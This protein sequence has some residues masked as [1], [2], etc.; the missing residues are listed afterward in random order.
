MGE[1]VMGNRLLAS[2]VAA[3]ALC[4][5]S[6]S[7]AHAAE[8][9]FYFGMSGGMASQDLSK[10]ALDV[11]GALIVADSLA[12]DDFSLLSYEPSDFDDNDAAWALQVGYQWG[13]YFAVELGYV[14][15]GDAM[16]A[17]DIL[18]SDDLV[19]LEDIDTTVSTRFRNS[20][21]TAAAVGIFPLGQ[22]F[23][24]HGRGGVLFARSR[25]RQKVDSEDSEALR[26][27]PFE[28]RG[29]STDLFAGLGAAWNINPSYSLRVEYTRYLNV[30]DEEKTLETDIDLI[31][32]T[33]L[34]R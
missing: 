32:L 27:V 28:L 19:I 7:G 13:S 9:G 25:I 21:I 10:K 23:E 18:V 14:N 30:G 16:H 3:G 11:N 17:A 26:V 20:G 24:V 15:L 31:S 6:V 4:V 33:L 8:G 1:Q 22:H 29:N 34:F 2:C 12:E 5:G